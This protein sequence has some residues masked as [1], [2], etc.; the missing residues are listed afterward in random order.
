MKLNLWLLVIINIYYVLPYLL[1]IF[2]FMPCVI[3]PCFI[4]EVY[5]RFFCR[6]VV[7]VV[8]RYKI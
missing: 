2:I 3:R 1:F 8:L 7:R 4:S 5:I 6:V